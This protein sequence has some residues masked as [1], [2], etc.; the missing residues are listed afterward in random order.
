MPWL[1]AN[2]PKGQSVLNYTWV[3]VTRH[4]A[5]KS[6]L[7]CADLK[8]NSERN[9]VFCPTPTA[10][11]IRIFAAVTVSK[12]HYILV[13][14]VVSAYPNARERELVLMRAPPEYKEHLRGK[15]G[16]GLMKG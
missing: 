7:T 13:G 1:K 8:A 6:R 11:S 15:I 12:G 10:S 5:A 14:D 9:D 3:D 4:A 2:V 16:R